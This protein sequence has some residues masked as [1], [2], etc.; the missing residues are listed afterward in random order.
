M[1]KKNVVTVLKPFPCF[2]TFDAP[3]MNLYSY[4]LQVFTIFTTWMIWWRG[5]GRPS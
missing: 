3:Q 1:K 4:S 2:L 5:S